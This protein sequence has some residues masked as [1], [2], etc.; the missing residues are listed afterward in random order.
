MPYRYQDDHNDH[1]NHDL[2]KK[3]QYL[4]KH[5]KMTTLGSK[6]PTFCRFVHS[7]RYTHP[8]DKPTNKPK[9]RWNQ[10][11]IGRDELNYKIIHQ[12]M[13]WGLVWSCLEIVWEENTHRFICCCWP[14]ILWFQCLQAGVFKIK[15]SQLQTC[16]APRDYSPQIKHV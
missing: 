14:H 7:L 11:L 6:E 10:D 12:S 9:V 8:S 13:Y 2:S 16:G 4:Q 1:Q 5:Y 15:A 3:I